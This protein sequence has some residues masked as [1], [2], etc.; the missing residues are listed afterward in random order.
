MPAPIAAGDLLDISEFHTPEFHSVVRVSAT[1][2]VNLPMVGE[3]SLNGL[4]ET[5]AA[6]TIA[7]ALITSGMLNHPQVFVLVTAYAGQDV[8]VLGQVARPGVYPYA[9]HHRLFDL[10]ST[11]SGLTP[12]A[13]G[14]VNVY[15]RNDPDTP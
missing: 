14:V 11:A 12:D 7:Q 8:T 15:H 9:V 1:G 4:D 10:I 2:T 3:I 13:G 6:H 5:A